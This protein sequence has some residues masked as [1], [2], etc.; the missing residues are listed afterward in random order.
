MQNFRGIMQQIRVRYNNNCLNAAVAFTLKYHFQLWLDCLNSHCTEVIA[1]PWETRHHRGSRTS[2]LAYFSIVPPLFLPCSSL[3]PLVFFPYP[4]LIPP[5]PL[6]Y[7]FLVLT[8]FLSCSSLTHIRDWNSENK[9]GGLQNKGRGT[10][11]N[12]GG[13]NPHKKRIIKLRGR[14]KLQ[15]MR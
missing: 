8:F 13:F 12:K 14:G 11:K 7:S 1:I 6:P 15:K 3:A 10:Y 2:A 9:G 4:S 5:L